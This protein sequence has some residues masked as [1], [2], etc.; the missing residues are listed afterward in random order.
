MFNRRM[1][2][3]ELNDTEKSKM[4]K[5]SGLLVGLREYHKVSDAEALLMLLVKAEIIKSNYLD[6]MITAF[7][8]DVEE[9][10]RAKDV[11]QGK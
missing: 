6:D 1:K 8:R 7:T 5:A 10:E 9:M 2:S 3:L 11:L 4:V